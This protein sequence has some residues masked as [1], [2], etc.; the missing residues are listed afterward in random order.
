MENNCFWNFTEIKLDTLSNQPMRA[1]TKI[2]TFFE[3]TNKANY[4]RYFL[5]FSLYM[6]TS[7][8]STHLYLEKFGDAISVSTLKIM[9]HEADR[10]FAYRILAPT[11]LK[12][13]DALTSQKIKE[14]I[15]YNKKHLPRKIV[16]LDRYNWQ[17]NNIYIFVL[18]YL[19]IFSLLVIIQMLWRFLLQTTIDL[20]KSTYDLAPTLAILILPMT[21]IKG[22]Y[23]YDFPDLLFA[24][25]CLVFFLKKKMDRILFSIRYRLYKQGKQYYSRR[26]VFAFATT[27]GF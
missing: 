9:N 18:T 11:L 24:T 1:L 10:P 16:S 21:Y 20:R 15:T 19:L 13:A 2:T 12:W 3:K 17:N 22:A 25:L 23:I 26:M 14:K 4:F 27:K 5:V 7:S 6:I 8:I